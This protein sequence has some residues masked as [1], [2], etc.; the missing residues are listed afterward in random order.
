[1]T[2]TKPAPATLR[3][4]ALLFDMDG[5]LVDSSAVVERIWRQFARRHGLDPAELLAASH[6]RRTGDVIARFAPA[7]VDVAAETALTVA[8]E[9][10]DSD[11]VAAVPGAAELL[12]GLPA[13]RWA[14]VT[15]AGRDL[16][17]RRMAMA[18]LDLPS[19]I[20]SAD[21]VHAGKPD[22]EGYLAAA[23]RLGVPAATTIV[24]EDTDAGLAAARAAGA[25]EVAVGTRNGAA[26]RGLPQ[27]SDF[28]TVT[29]TS[30]GDGWLHLAL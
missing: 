12:A 1:M 4:R 2:G 5:T 28:R 22:P 10:D 7:G 26:A 8:Q 20:I 17:V 19:V 25:R 15:S 21:D 27:I 11:G 29:A 14:L 24:F 3:A 13:D 6:G 16:A 30:A 9:V 23:S 18:G